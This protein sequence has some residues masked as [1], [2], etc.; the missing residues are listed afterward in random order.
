MQEQKPTSSAERLKEVMNN[1]RGKAEDDCDLLLYNGPIAHSGYQAVLDA[2]PVSVAEAVALFLITNGGDAHAGFRIARALRRRY[3]KFR[4]IVPSFCKSA[5]TLIAIGANEL[6]MFEEGELGPLDVQLAKRDEVLERESG[7]DTVVALMHLT[8]NAINAFRDTFIEIVA[9]AGLGSQLSGDLA[10]KLVTGLYSPTFA[11]IDPVSLGA[12]IRANQIGEHY[13]ERIGENLHP[14]ALRKLVS[15]YPAH[16]CVIDHEEAR[17]LFKNVRQPTE[18]EHALVT[19]LGESVRQ[20]TYESKPI[21]L[22]LSQEGTDVI[23]S[24]HPASI[25]S[26]VGAAGGQSERCNNTRAN[27]ARA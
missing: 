19:L 27:S 26:S 16:E 8:D 1:L 15:G 5:G 20:P 21:V 7:M 13:G 22:L 14:G 18:T 12:K 17:N 3:E 2:L 23:Q 10:T 9:G 4:V 24:N 11:Q 6:V 25:P